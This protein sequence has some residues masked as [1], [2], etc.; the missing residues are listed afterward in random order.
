LAREVRFQ[1]SI[2][3]VMS[4]AFAIY[5]R[6]LI[7]FLVLGTV[8]FSPLIALEIATVE[9]TPEEALPIAILSFLLTLLLPQVL[10][11]TLTHGVLQQLLGKPAPLGDTIAQGFRALFRVIGT[12]FLVGLGV[13]LA[14]FLLI[15]PGLYLM[16][17]WYVAV[18][19]AVVEGKAGT[20]AMA[21]SRDLVQGYGWQVFWLIVLIVL[22][23]VLFVMAVGA[24]VLFAQGG[25]VQRASD[26]IW[27][28]LPIQIVTTTF[29]STLMAVLYF[30][31]RQGRENVD[32]Q[33]IASVFG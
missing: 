7:P 29:G 17:R 26:S 3:S 32:V 30:R 20:A 24:I 6:N 31:L 23:N 10:T 8:A 4:Q 11:G 19:V 16:V 14:S 33:Q 1:F 21:R 15:I 12:G 25:T 18:P 9:R 28:S 22:M 2:G 5:L 13:G 27:F